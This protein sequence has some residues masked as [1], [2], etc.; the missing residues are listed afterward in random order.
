M[1][2]LLA[3]QPCI[4]LPATCKQVSSCLPLRGKGDRLRWM[5]CFL[6][7]LF[8]FHYSTPF[9]LPPHPSTELTPSPQG[10]GMFFSSVNLYWTTRQSRGIRYTKKEIAHKDN[11][12]FLE[13]LAGLEPAT[14]WLRI[15]CSTDWATVASLSII[16]TF[17]ANVNR[18]ILHISFLYYFLFLVL[19]KWWQMQ[20]H[21]QADRM[22]LRFGEVA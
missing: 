15:S 1:R 19:D 3:C 22:R 11:L 7:N 4:G 20:Y 6:D 12:F 16:L 18:K 10:E 5:R 8:F 21:K 2:Y 9:P 17:D 14:C 13:L